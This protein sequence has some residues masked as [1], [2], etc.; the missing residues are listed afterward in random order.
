MRTLPISVRN[1][2]FN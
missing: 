1:I 2:A